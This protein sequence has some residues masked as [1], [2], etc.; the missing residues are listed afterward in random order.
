MLILPEASIEGNLEINQIRPLNSILPCHP[1]CGDRYFRI[2]SA[3]WFDDFRQS[4]YLQKTVNK[5][6]GFSM[7]MSGSALRSLD[8]LW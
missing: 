7:M 1:C 6:A 2:G 8:K 3:T 4:T 5:S